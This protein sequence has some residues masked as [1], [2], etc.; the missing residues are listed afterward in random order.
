MGKIGIALLILSM[1]M[2]ESE[3][4]WIP[5]IIMGAGLLLI[6]AEKRS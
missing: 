4:L 5:A 2:A 1:T 6:C 3:N